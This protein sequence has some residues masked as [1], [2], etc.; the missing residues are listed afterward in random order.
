MKSQGSHVIGGLC[1]KIRAEMQKEKGENV[2]LS[3]WKVPKP[4]LSQMLSCVRLH[5]L[6]QVQSDFL[7]LWLREWQGWTWWNWRNT[8]WSPALP[9]KYKRET[10]LWQVYSWKIIGMNLYTNRDRLTDIESKHDNQ[11]GEGL[12]LWIFKLLGPATE[13]A[14][15][16]FI[17]EK[18]PLK[19]WKPVVL[20]FCN[21]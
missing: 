13:M 8:S 1:V 7:N 16:C 20:S 2:L 15:C 10:G 18:W 6:Y 19:V 17:F 3:N 21:E 5:H 4:F 14:F 12:W 11:R 9:A